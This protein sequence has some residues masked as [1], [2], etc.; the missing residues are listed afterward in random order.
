M[1]YATFQTLP[2]NY[3]A[4]EI[5]AEAARRADPR[6]WT[7]AVCAALEAKDL[8]TILEVFPGADEAP[9]K[10]RKKALRD[11]RKDVLLPR[12][13][14]ADAEAW[15]ASVAAAP[16]L[17]APVNYAALE[18]TPFCQE[19]LLEPGAK[20]HAD[21]IDWVRLRAG[22]T[23]FGESISAKRHAHVTNQP[24][25]ACP[26]GCADHK[27][28]PTAS[29]FE[30]PGTIVA[31]EIWVTGRER[32]VPREAVANP[33]AYLTEI[34]RVPTEEGRWEHN[35]LFVGHALRLRRGAASHAATNWIDAEEESGASGSSLEEG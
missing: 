17:V 33:E 20:L 29:L 9:H 27:D 34:L 22:A 23:H 32:W 18:T 25:P 12:M 8:P 21:Y 14:E 31:R 24:S 26:F 3:V 4:R 16:Q 19:V 13:R 6:S 15:T 11:Y 2:E 28:S 10:E 7:G 5:I 1:L 35:L 30:C